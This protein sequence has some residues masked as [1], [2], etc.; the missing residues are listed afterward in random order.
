M[1]TLNKNTDSEL[2]VSILDEMLKTIDSVISIPFSQEEVWTLGK[3]FDVIDV[4]LWEKG[5]YTDKNCTSLCLPFNILRHQVNS[6]FQYHLT[7]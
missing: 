2:E 3:E 6:F 5:F 4:N 7:S 1:K